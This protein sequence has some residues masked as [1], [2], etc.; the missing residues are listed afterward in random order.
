MDNNTAELRELITKRTADN[1]VEFES[2]NKLTARQRLDLIFD[3]GTFVE[4]GSFIGTGNESSIDNYSSVITG[5]GSIDGNLV[6]A[7]SQDFSRTLG[8]I[9]PDHSKKIT[10]IIKLAESKKALLIGIFDSA[11]TQ[12][13]KGVASLYNIGEA[14]CALEKA[15]KS[16]YTIAI[17]AGICG[18]ISAVF[19]SEFAFKILSKENASLYI[20]P[21]TALN[22]KSITEPENTSKIGLVDLLADS[23]KSACEY[24]VKLSK[25]LTNTIK[26]NDNPNRII[27]ES[28]LSNDIDIY[29][30]IENVVDKGTFFELTSNHA[31]SIVTGL[32]TINNVVTAIIACNSKIH[33]GKVCACAFDKTAKFINKLNVTDKKLP[34]L[35][36]VNANGLKYCDKAESNLYSEKISSLVKAY[37]SYN[38]RPISVS[39][40]LKEAYGTAYTVLGSKPLGTTINLAI[41][42]AKIGVINPLTAVE[43]LSEVKDEANADKYASD[44]AEKNASP[45]E[46]ARLGYID[47]IISSKELR[48]RIAAAIMMFIV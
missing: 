9:T 36:L 26:S 44:W 43:F 3:E 13:D 14:M 45:I 29:N 38:D 10:N 41:D 11:G 47:D 15:K 2:K 28:I 31:K 33:D 19:A 40:V 25:Y 35:T 22:D 12:I 17:I 5:Y 18:G 6:F 30:V 48:Q 46:A 32:A 23:D 37:V 42:N 4:I 21:K 8:A 16:I 34:L 39:V 20:S 24:A 7:F 27:D 1:S